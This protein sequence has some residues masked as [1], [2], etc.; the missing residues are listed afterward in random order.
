MADVTLVA[1]IRLASEEGL[2]RITGVAGEAF[3]LTAGEIA[4]YVAADGLIYRSITIAAGVGSQFDGMITRSVAV[5]DPVT[6][7]QQGY[8][9]RIGAHGLNVGAFVWPSVTAGC[10]ADANAGGVKVEDPIGRAV[11]ATVIEITRMDKPNVDNT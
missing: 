11:S 2:G 6:L 10:I 5:G 1:P 8:K 4:G 3:D 9:I 7:F